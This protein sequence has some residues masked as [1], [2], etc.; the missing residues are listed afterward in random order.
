MKDFEHVQKN[1]RDPENNNEVIIAPRNFL[2]NPPKK[3]RVGKNTSFAGVISYME[4][5]FDI[6][7]E[8]ATKERIAGQELMQEKPFSQKVKQT[9]YFN[10]HKSVIGEDVVIPARDPP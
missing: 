2:I 5:E 9:Q 7:K 3:G 6:P 8:I 4:S 10:S 1:H